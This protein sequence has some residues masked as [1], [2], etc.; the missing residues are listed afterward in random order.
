MPRQGA[1]RPITPFSA[2]ATTREIF[3]LRS[4]PLYWLP[5]GFPPLRRGRLDYRLTPELEPTLLLY[6]DLFDR[7]ELTFEAG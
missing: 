1:W 6:G 7:L 2:T 5:C 3:K 4:P